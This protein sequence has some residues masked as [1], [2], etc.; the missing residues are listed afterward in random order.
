MESTRRPRK[1]IGEIAIF[2]RLV[3]SA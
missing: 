3:G 1:V 2:F